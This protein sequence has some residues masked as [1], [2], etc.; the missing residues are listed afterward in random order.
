VTTQ[1]S[2]ERS[3]LSYKREPPEMDSCCSKHIPTWSRAAL[4]RKSPPSAAN[5]LPPWPRSDVH[6]DPRQKRPIKHEYEGTTLLGEDSEALGRAESLA[7]A[8]PDLW[9][10]IPVGYRREMG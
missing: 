9:V 2:G 3:A 5:S 8:C 10:Y 6:E 7:K 4:S 1:A